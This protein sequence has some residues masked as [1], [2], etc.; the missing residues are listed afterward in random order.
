[1]ALLGR[2]GRGQAAGCEGVFI[3]VEGGAHVR[4]EG[5][6]FIIRRRDQLGRTV[7]R[8]IRVLWEG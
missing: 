1:M 5:R 4:L 2:L 7:P 3:R 8:S 6:G